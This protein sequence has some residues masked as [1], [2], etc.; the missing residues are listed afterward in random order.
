MAAYLARRFAFAAV[1]VFLVSSASLLLTRLAPGDFVTETAG[2]GN[3]AAAERARA[4][5]GLNKP[6]ATQYREWLTQAARLDFG[7]SLAYDRPV[8]ELVPERAANTLTIA[9]TALGVATV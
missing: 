2:V 1:L 5:Y 7:R 3:V 4:R 6:L 8:A 9:L